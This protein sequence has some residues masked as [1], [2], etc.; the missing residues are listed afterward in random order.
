M[1]QALPATPVFPRWLLLGAG[2]L[3]G[4]TLVLASL[5][6]DVPVDPA[7]TGIRPVAT[8]D[9][10]FA[11]RPDGAVVVSDAR[12]GTHVLVLPPGQE[13]F[14]RGAMRGLVR[15]RK[16]EAIGTAAPFRLSAWP[17]GRVTLEDTATGQIIE[18]QAFGRSNAETFVRLLETEE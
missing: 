7:K 12:S 14:V 17:N 13:G 16:R 8:R 9:L 3:I 18:L 5:G 4:G 2:G 10:R 15:E 1:A 11:D 6:H